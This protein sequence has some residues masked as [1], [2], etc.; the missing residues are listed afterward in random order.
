MPSSS[1][2]TA[3]GGKE[4]A[5]EGRESKGGRKETGTLFWHQL[6]LRP[7]PPTLGRLPCWLSSEEPTCNAGDAGSIPVS[8]RDPGGGHG[9][10]LQCSCLE[11]S[12]D[13]G[14]L[15]GYSPLGSQELDMTEQLNRHR[16]PP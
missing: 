5:R 8:G 7:T 13:R 3:E 10:P 6:L 1:K 11:T 14:T 9:N 4:G 2:P 16:R 15:L 12:L